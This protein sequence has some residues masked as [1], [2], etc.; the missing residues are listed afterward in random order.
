MENDFNQTHFLFWQKWLFYTSLLFAV[1]GIL[2]AFWGDSLLFT[3][4]NKM[5]AQIFWHKNQFSAEEELFR[6]FIYGPLGGT[7]ACCY[8]LLAFIAWHP[9]KEKQLWAR[10]AIV[11]AFSIWVVIDSL[12]CLKFGVYPQIY[13]INAFSIIVKGLPIIFTWKNFSKNNL[14]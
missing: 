10:N 11:I 6:S 7:I 1:S 12:V 5:L 14:P 13:I 4:Y 9:F 3:Y 2:F 8:I